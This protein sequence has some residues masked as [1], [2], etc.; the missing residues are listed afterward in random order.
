MYKR[1]NQLE[2][3]VKASYNPDNTNN[4]VKEVDS[5]ESIM[6]VVRKNRLTVVDVYATWCGPCKSLAPRYELLAKKYKDRV[7]FLKIELQNIEDVSLAKEITALPTF[8][9]FRNDGT[10]ISWEKEAGLNIIQLE[11]YVSTM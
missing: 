1:Q 6:Q 3:E 10:S 7:A 4:V 11:Q 9:F 2:S 8:L 5:F